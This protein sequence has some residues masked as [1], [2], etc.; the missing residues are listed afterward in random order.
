MPSRYGRLSQVRGP[1]HHDRLDAGGVEPGHDGLQLRLEFGVA[2]GVERMGDREPLQIVRV[3]GAGFFVQC[4]PDRRRQ[5]VAPA[6]QPGIA[7]VQRGVATARNQLP[8]AVDGVEVGTSHDGAASTAR[9]VR[10]KT[11]A[12]SF[13]AQLMNVPNAD[14]V[15][16]MCPGSGSDVGRSYTGAMGE[17][18]S[19][20]VLPGR[21]QMVVPAGAPRRLPLGH[22][23]RAHGVHTA[24]SVRRASRGRIQI[25]HLIKMD[26]CSGRK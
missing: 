15:D 16:A 19:Q 13:A 2:L 17:V 24:A 7:P 23:A 22:D 8:K 3:P 25:D 10:V 6:E 14:G 9:H 20:N 26:H 11:D 12:D 4:R 5:Q 18:Y 1:F 21:A